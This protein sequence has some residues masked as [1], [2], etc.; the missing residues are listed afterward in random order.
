MQLK[1]V[2][3]PSSLDDQVICV[4]YPV[5]DQLNGKVKVRFFSCECSSHIVCPL[6]QLQHLAVLF[7]IPAQT[8]NVYRIY[9]IENE[10][11]GRTLNSITLP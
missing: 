2:S 10:I 6:N 8:V 3:P 7:C 1:A 4:P 11:K 9:L 5:S